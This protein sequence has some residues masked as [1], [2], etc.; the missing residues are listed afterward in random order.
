MKIIDVG[1]GSPVVLIPGVQGRWEWMRQGV[2]ALSKHCRVITFS[3]ADE[4]TCGAGFDEAAGFWCYV[5]QVAA[6]MDAAGVEKAT[7]CAVS[8]GGLIGAAFA[9]RHPERVSALIL[10][11]AIPPSWTPDAKLRFLMKAPRLLLPLFCIGSLRLLPEIIAAKGFFRG[12]PFAIGHVLTVVT[13]PFSPRLMA[14]RG[15]LITGLDIEDDVRRVACP[16]LLITGDGNLDRVVP[17]GLTRQY[18]R[19]WPHAI[20]VVLKRTGHLGLITA[21][22]D[23]ASLVS[24]FADRPTSAEAQRRRIG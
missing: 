12:I 20:D 18:L 2:E 16:T 14:R 11:S 15:R 21:A 23:F 22:D 13:N 8:Y 7:I 5:Q 6:A 1:S 3:L 9:A 4:P 10:V 19:I 24:G 17:T